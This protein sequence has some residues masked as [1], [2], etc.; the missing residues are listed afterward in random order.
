MSGYN[1][2]R[3]CFNPIPSVINSGENMFP[4]KISWFYRLVLTPLFYI[5]LFSCNSG[6]NQVGPNILFIMADDMGVEVLGS[7]GGKSY[8]TPNIDELAATGL[9]FLNCH[10]APACSPTR[11]K[12]LTGRYGFR[13]TQKWG[14][15]PPNEITFGHILTKAGYQVAISGKWQMALLKDDPNHIAKMGFPESAVFAWHEG[16]RYY[17]PMIYQNGKVREDVANRYGPEVF[18]DFLIDFI[19]KNQDRPF[20]A[21]YSMALAH[22]VSD[23]FDPPPPYGPNGRYDTYAEQVAYLD[24]MVGKMINALENLGVRDNTL[25]LFTADNGTPAHFITERKDGVFIR[26]KIFSQFG[27][28]LIQGGKTSTTDGGTHVPLIANWPE[29]IPHGKINAD[30]IDFTDFMPTFAELTGAQLPQNTSID[31]ISFAPQILG[32]AG[33]PRK[34]LYTLY[35]EHAWIRDLQWKLYQD[36]RFY[37]I[38]NDPF[39][40]NALS[41]KNLSENE[42]EIKDNFQR[43]LLEMK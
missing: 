6:K 2:G 34:W 40:Q 43:I 8:E 22:D 12:L 11:V 24:K 41:P 1:F 20:F 31:G 42:Q 28:T 26:E 36:G 18:S 30:L 19:K 25:I 13:T 4:V 37:N 32:R 3:D 21:Y 16:P 5:L 9:R 15:I 14:Y 23:D 17:Q 27:D 38:K 7:Y 29:V 33:T 39:E 35:E 10:S